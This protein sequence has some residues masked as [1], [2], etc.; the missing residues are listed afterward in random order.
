MN[1]AVDMPPT[2]PVAPRLKLADWL[3]R[4][5][6]AKAWWAAIP[7]WWTGMAVSTKVAPLEVFYDS[8]LAGFLNV[9]FF[10][11]TALMVLGVG[12]VQQWLA[13]V[14][15]RGDG[16]PLSDDEAARIARLWEQHERDMENLRAGSDIFDPRSGGLYIGN[17]SSLQHPNRFFQH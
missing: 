9:A 4:P 16:V 2:D 10:P 11:M 1:T 8:A 13:S 12:F 15:P 14:S 17:P 5:W 3:W 6:Y 7:V